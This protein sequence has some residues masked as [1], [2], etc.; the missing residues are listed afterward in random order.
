MKDTILLD[1]LGFLHYSIHDLNQLLE[2]IEDLR[3]IFCGQTKLFTLKIPITII[4]SIQVQFD[5]TKISYAIHM[6]ILSL[7]NFQTFHLLPLSYHNSII[8]PEK[9]YV[10]LVTNF[11]EIPCQKLEER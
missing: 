3:N 4:H 11:E 5:K 2:M 10:I 9:P 7:A 1:R 8:I 6:P